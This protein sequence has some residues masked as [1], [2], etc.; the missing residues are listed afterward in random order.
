MWDDSNKNYVEFRYCTYDEDGEPLVS[1]SRRVVG[2][3]TDFLPNVLREFSYFLHGMTFTYVNEV[4]AKS[5]KG[6]EIASSDDFD[7]FEIEEEE[8]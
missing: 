1:I 6:E 7:T 2:D 5:G 8:D 3:D 4:I